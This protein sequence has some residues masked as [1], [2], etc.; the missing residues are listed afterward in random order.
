MTGK[1]KLPQE[2]YI[3]HR[4]WDD[5]LQADWLEGI[6]RLA[7]SK[8]FIEAANWFD[9]IDAYAYIDNGGLLGSPNARKKAAFHRLLKLKTD[10]ESLPVKK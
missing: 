4:H 6:Y 10:W 5:E 8:S 3:W 1:Y 7:Y 2:S 9:L